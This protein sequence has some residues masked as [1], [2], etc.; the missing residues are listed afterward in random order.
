MRYVTLRT[1]R[2]GFFRLLQPNTWPRFALLSGARGFRH[3]IHRSNSQL[4]TRMELSKEQ[5]LLTELQA[6]S[7]RLNEVIDQIQSGAVDLD[8]VLSQIRTDLKELHV[9]LDF[10]AL[11][12]A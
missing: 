2:I 11:S 1:L 7:N 9:R 6:L 8:E 12:P 10:H 4:L 5:N 3:N